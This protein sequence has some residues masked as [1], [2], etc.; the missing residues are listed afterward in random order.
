[1]DN[2]SQI[3]DYSMMYSL[4]MPMDQSYLNSLISK[5]TFNGAVK[6]SEENQSTNLSETHLPGKLGF[7]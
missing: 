5:D 4:G 1:M 6:I 3:P 7:I 2:F